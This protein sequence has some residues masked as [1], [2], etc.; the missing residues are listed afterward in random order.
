MIV[1]PGLRIIGGVDSKWAKYRPP[2]SDHT[3][4]GLSRGNT[5]VSGQVEPVSLVSLSI[6]RHTPTTFIT[7]KSSRPVPCRQFDTG[8]FKEESWLR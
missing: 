7:K 5:P 8:S 3:N 6:Q 4:H 1:Q 2:W